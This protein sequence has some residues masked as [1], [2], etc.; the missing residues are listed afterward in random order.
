MLTPAT[1]SS[2]TGSG[3]DG[4]GSLNAAVGPLPEKLQGTA[5]A[6]HREQRRGPELRGVFDGAHL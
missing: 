6:E 4:A 1:S 3:R 2:W 5:N